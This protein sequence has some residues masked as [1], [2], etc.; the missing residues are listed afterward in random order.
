[1]VAGVLEQNAMHCGAVHGI[2]SDG[3]FGPHCCCESV[4]SSSFYAHKD[5]VT[6]ETDPRRRGF[7]NADPAPMYSSSYPSTLPLLTLLALVVVFLC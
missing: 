6:P 1:M 3:D 2:Q 7:I 5:T 4:C